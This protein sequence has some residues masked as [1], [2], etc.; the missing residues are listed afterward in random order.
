MALTLPAAVYLDASAAEPG[1]GLRQPVSTERA[2]QMPRVFMSLE[3][4]EATTDQRAQVKVA[5]SVQ[6]PRT[7]TGTVAR[8]AMGSGPVRVV[9]RTNGQVY[10]VR[11]RL[12]FG[13]GVISLPL[14]PQ[15]V[16]RVRATFLGNG[17]LGKGTSAVRVLN[18]VGPG[19]APP[20]PT[21]TPTP[22]ATAYG[23]PHGDADGDGDGD[24]DGDCDADRDWVTPTPTVTR[25]CDVEPTPTATVTATHGSTPVTVTAT[26]TGDGHADGDRRLGR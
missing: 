14:L 1:E 21:P 2:V 4:R 6:G 18:V 24:A 9:A 10:A 12:V 8:L 19:S 16:Y 7:L 20:P 17:L 25:D 11:D 3:G 13:T 5:L 22:T 15:G 23:D 26:P